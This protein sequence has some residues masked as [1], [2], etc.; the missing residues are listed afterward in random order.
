[1][2]VICKISEIIVYISFVT[3]SYTNRWILSFR[4]YQILYFTCVTLTKFFC[5]INRFQLG[6]SEPKYQRMLTKST[7]LPLWEDYGSRWQRYL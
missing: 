2:S 1:M 4:T 5:G 7:H 3:L 6:Y